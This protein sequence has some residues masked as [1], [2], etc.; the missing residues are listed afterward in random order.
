MIV[1]MTTTK[2]KYQLPT[3]IYDGMAELMKDIHM[4][5]SNVRWHMRGECKSPW[6][7]EVEIEEE[8][9]EEN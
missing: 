5:R 2:D 7:F 4:S 1:Y 3:G 9:E 6:I 8:I